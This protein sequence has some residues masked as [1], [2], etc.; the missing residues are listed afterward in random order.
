MDFI[1]KFI[2]QTI[3]CIHKSVEDLEM[4]CWRN[5]FSAIVPLFTWPHNPI[6]KIEK[7]HL[8]LSI[9]IDIYHILVVRTC[10][11]N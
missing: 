10:A 7:V 8:H 4:E 3:K 6:K 9:P 11:E 1:D 2:A 5:D